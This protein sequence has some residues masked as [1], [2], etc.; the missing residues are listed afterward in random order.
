[1]SSRRFW[2]TLLATVL[3]LAVVVSGSGIV[4][5]DPP[6]SIVI[7]GGETADVFNYSNAIRQRVWVDSNY[8]SDSNGTNDLIAVDIIRPAES[9]Q[10]MKVPVIMDDSPYY[11][12]LGRGN[13]SQ[14]KVDDSNGD[15][16]L[17]RWPLFLDNFFVGRGY[18]VV[19]TDMTGTS[20]STGCPTTGGATDNAAGPEVLEWLNGTRTAHDK[21]G[22]LVTAPWYSGRA[23]LI[24]KSYDGTLANA[25]AVAGIPGLVTIVPE[26]AIS[27]WYFYTRSNGIRFNN[28]YPSSLSNTVTNSTN[29]APPPGTSRTLCAPTRA[30]LDAT[31]GDAT[32]DY[33]AFWSER[34]YL[35]DASKVTASVFLTHGLND[36]NV[37]TDN[38]SEWW[39]AL[40][41]YNVPRKLWLMQTGHVDP[42]D[43]NRAV[44]VDTLH[45]WFD[46][47]L[48]NVPNGIMSEPQVSME[49]GP[50]TWTTL[51]SWP[52]PASTPTQVFLKP[53]PDAGTMGLTPAA[54]AEVTTTYADTSSSES[55]FINN[56]TTVTA[57]RRVFLSPVLTAPLQLSGTALVQ[58][59][60]SA[61][62]PDTNLGALLVDYGPSGSWA[63]KVN[64]S[65]NEGVQN[66]TT[67]SCWGDSSATDSACYID[68]AE[69]LTTPT[70]NWRVSKG[71][72]DA[73]NRNSVTTGTPL[74]PGAFDTF[75][76]PM[77]PQDYTFPAGHQIGLVVIGNFSGYSEATGG[78][79]AAANITLSLKSSRIVLPI[80][81]GHDAALASGLLGTEPTTTT[82]ATR[83]DP[84]DIGSPV[85]FS[86]TV[87]PVDPEMATTALPDFV[88]RALPAGVAARFTGLGTPTGSVQWSLDGAP[89]DGPARLDAL[90]RATFTAPRLDIGTHVVTAEYLGPGDFGPSRAEIAH[91]VKKRLGT[92]VAVTSDINPSVF[93]QTVNYSATVSPENLSSGQPV[94]GVVQFQVNGVPVGGPQPLAGG[95]ASMST[96]ALT[97][98][99]RSIRASYLGDTH[100]TGSTSPVYSQHVHRATPVVVVV[101]SDPD[102]VFGTHMTFTATISTSVTIGS[103]T[104]AMVQFTIDGTA[105][106][107]PA[108]VDATNQVSLTVTWSLPLGSHSVRARYLG[109][110]DFA[111]VT[112]PGITQKIH[113]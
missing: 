43:N 92:S 55:T 89:V 16:L 23:A 71:I 29:L 79:T 2:R 95:V 106:G 30:N 22:N 74:T 20:H 112:S 62:Q 94:T 1:M 34:D 37:K 100:Y 87:A 110:A 64:R 81:G 72:L 75:S 54:G 9:D 82:V 3:P 107:A 6:P 102:A 73:L 101:S 108:A 40:S 68:V 67:S 46:Y 65:S 11:T 42:F 33:T 61:N 4:R 39:Y 26:S 109:D 19:L 91:T 57:N 88:A 105:M 113:G 17:A 36:D 78:F 111:P 13:E 66:L 58:L 76:F 96:N 50:G 59:K 83:F 63:P 80:V 99:T 7:V 56:P 35:K 8:D 49:T 28:H 44:W 60:A 27:S 52:D 18:A 12:T 51:P 85:E 14:L 32:G 103:L 15:G 53:G 25:A 38:F 10:G 69:R 47:W 41:T 90:G 97:A 93:G 84:T 70:A 24:G 86:A 45:R 104:P 31:D 5:A 21:D 98:G 77:L 48:W